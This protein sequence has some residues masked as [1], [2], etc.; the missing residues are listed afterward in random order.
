MLFGTKHCGGGGLEI[1]GLMKGSRGRGRC[2]GLQGLGLEAT[3]RCF[4]FRL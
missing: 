4:G 3:A 2:M 1:H